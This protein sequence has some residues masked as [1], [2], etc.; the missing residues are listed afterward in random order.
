VGPVTG[1]RALSVVAFDGDDTLWHNESVFSITHERF[2][3]LLGAYVDIADLDDRL[4]AIEMNN[5]QI[6][7]YGVK[8]FVLSM[9]ETAI[10]VTGGRV[11]TSDIQSI[12]DAGKAMLVHPVELLPGAA[13]ALDAAAGRYRVMLVTKGDLL[14]QESKLA[15]SGLAEKFW[16]IEVVADKNPATY[17]RILAAHGIE[18][19][20]F[21][22]I[23]DS[24]RSDVAPV[25][26]VGGR[27]VHVP[28]AITWA[29]E[30]AEVD[31][32]HERVWH[33]DNLAGLPPLLAAID[34]P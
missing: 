17:R 12:I 6:F 27:A 20:E 3:E 5:L 13:E 31:H 19:E 29:H 22:M 1:A 8:S 4:F 26:E 14:D 15:R 24:L 32:N 7:G 11:S 25:L 2:R 21:L 9:I 33:L 28:Y 18:P 34:R 30:R 23:G 16:R 10:E